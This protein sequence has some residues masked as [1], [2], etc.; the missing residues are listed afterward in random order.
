MT[1]EKYYNVVLEPI[2]FQHLTQIGE[3][4][5][6]MHDNERSHKVKV[7]IG[8]PLSRVAN[9]S[10]VRYVPSYN[11]HYP[12]A[13]TDIGS[14][15]KTNGSRLPACIY[16]PF[17]KIVRKKSTESNIVRYWQHIEIPMPS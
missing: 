10:A 12:F 7:P 11:I 16:I 4:F 3:N 1:T 5:Q 2:V 17:S 8:V 14:F 13:D 15:A 6:L 9:K